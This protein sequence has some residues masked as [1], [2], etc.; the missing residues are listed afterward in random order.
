LLRRP[1]WWIGFGLS[2]V[3]ALLNLIALSGAP[4]SVA[5]PIAVL[6]VPFAVLLGMWRSHRRP[7]R[8]V[9]LSIAAAMIGV[10]LFVTLAAVNTDSHN[11]AT[12]D[13]LLSGL[14]AAAF[15]V[16]VLVLGRRG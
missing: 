11:P 7:N 13:I 5:Q 14:F 6:S 1:L 9:W 10:T 15:V 12:S 8:A 4:V 2:G 16:G 3:G